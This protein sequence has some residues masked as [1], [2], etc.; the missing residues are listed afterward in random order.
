[1]GEMK[2][3]FVVSDIHGHCT[4]LKNALAEAGFDKNNKDH[5]L[6]CCGDLFDRGTENLQ[7]L[8]FIDC[9]DNKVLIMGNHEEMLLEIFRTGKLKPHN[10]DN[11]TVE[12]MVEFFGKYAIDGFTGEVDFSGNSRMVDRVCGLIDEMCDY[13][14]TEKYVF[15]HGWIPTVIRDE[16]PVIYEGWRTASPSMWSEARWKKWPVMYGEGALLADKTIVCGHYP[17][18]FA[19][20]FDRSRAPGSSE[21][22]RDKGIIA[23]DAGTFTSGRINVLVIEDRI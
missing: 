8:K 22:F 19:N 10:F 3:F 21:P 14:E 4:I 15:T 12:T 23:I 2:K 5:V 16:K 11:G 9:I 13:F 6:V 7:V 20:I 17:A 1:M 18:I